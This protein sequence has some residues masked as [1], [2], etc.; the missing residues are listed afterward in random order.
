MINLDNLTGRSVKVVGGK[1][2]MVLTVSELHWLRENDP[3]RIEW[4]AGQPVVE[5][6]LDTLLLAAQSPRQNQPS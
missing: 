5:L 2:Y 6:G 1:T 4:V 3:H